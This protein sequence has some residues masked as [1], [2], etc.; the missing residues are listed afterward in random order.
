MILA[1]KVRR[2][3]WNTDP[4]TVPAKT[5]LSSSLSREVIPLPR[6]TVLNCKGEM[7]WG[8]KRWKT[9]VS[10]QT[11]LRHDLVGSETVVGTPEDD[12]ELGTVP[13][14]SLS[15]TR[16]IVPSLEPTSNSLFRCFKRH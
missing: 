14:S 9:K 5:P 15:M 2:S 12:L 1:E 13:C 16:E 3:K 7:C 11:C 6:L 4:F 10:T 8:K